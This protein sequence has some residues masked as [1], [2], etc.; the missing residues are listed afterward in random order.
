VVEVYDIL[1]SIMTTQIATIPKKISGG[2]ELIVV[3][4]SDFATYQEWQSE[5][6]DA[7]EKVRRGR[8]EYK[9]RKTVIA[10]SPR[11]FR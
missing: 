8:I 4:K 11:K 1:K 6:H 7:L 3:R 2:E 5:I 10:H 9:Q